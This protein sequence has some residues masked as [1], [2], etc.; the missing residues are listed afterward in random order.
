MNDFEFAATNLRMTVDE[1]KELVEI[2]LDMWDCGI[3]VPFEAFENLLQEDSET[4]LSR[5]ALI[6]KINS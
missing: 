5:F 1:Y 3:R 6:D 4:I 2:Y